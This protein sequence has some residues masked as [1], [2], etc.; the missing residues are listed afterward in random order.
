MSDEKSYQLGDMM[1]AFPVQ[2][3]AKMLTNIDR[4]EEDV[5]KE[6]KE[7]IDALEK[8]EQITQKIVEENL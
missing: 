7:E 4:F 1:K 5:P 8:A 3:F 6:R 2:E